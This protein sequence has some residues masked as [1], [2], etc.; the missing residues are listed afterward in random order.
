MLS[1]AATFHLNL[2]TRTTKNP[3]MHY[4]EKSSVFTKSKKF[5]SYLKLT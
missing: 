5:N 4:H 3:C 1:F 2:I